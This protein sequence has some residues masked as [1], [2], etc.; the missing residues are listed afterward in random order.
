M[1]DGGIGLRVP[2][3]LT[4]ASPTVAEH[5]DSRYTEY[6]ARGGDER[7]GSQ[8]SGNRA[9]F[10]R[11]AARRPAFPLIQSKDRLGLAWTL[12]QEDLAAEGKLN[13]LAKRFDE[14]GPGHF[15]RADLGTSGGFRYRRAGRT[16]DITSRCKRTDGCRRTISS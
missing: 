10:G 6:G 16:C 3:K 4:S 13:S 8:P 12:M 15:H 11:R 5:S 2:G 7:R 9:A 14:F 1:P